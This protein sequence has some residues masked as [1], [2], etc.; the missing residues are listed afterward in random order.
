MG[1]RLGQLSLP[2][3]APPCCV[4]PPQDPKPLPYLRH[5]Q[6]YTFDINLSVTLKGTVTGSEGVSR[7][8]VGTCAHMPLP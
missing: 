7:G 8:V 4:L 2:A 5:D 6:P 1:P 3:H